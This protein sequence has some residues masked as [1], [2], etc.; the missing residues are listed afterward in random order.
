MGCYRRILPSVYLYDHCVKPDDG[1]CNITRN[2]ENRFNQNT[3]E[4]PKQWYSLDQ[5]FS[6]IISCGSPEIIFNIPRNS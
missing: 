3:V 1:E 5:R 4:I 2:I 6:N